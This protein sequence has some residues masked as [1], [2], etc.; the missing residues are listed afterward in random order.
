MSCSNRLCGAVF[1]QD[2]TNGTETV[3]HRFGIQPGDGAEPS[4]ALLDRP[5][6][7]LGTTWYGGKVNGVCPFGCGV[8]YAVRTNGAHTV[9]HSFTGGVDGSAP[10]GD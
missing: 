8:V 10:S 9:L 5:G 3:L 4:G 1:S 6:N 2:T 7:L